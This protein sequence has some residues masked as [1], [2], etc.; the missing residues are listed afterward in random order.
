MR[1]SL[2][3]GLMKR[4]SK[5]S[6]A[7]PT[8]VLMC[9]LASI[10]A[11]TT[12]FTAEILTKGNNVV[13]IQDDRTNDRIQFDLDTGVYILIRCSDGISFTG[14]GRVQQVRCLTVLRDVS[15]SRSL[16]AISQNDP[17]GTHGLF[18]MVDRNSRV[19]IVGYDNDVTD[20]RT[21]S[22]NEE[23]SDGNCSCSDWGLY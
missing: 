16:Y 15:R 20:A 22:R 1:M 14:T 8:V 9:L 23:I 4:F 5:G 12:G 13:C 3:L 10:F 17:C 11:S 2:D 18:Q 21:V 7:I 6:L 19:K